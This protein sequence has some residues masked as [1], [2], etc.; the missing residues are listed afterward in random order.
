VAGPVQDLEDRIGA[1]TARRAADRRSV[2]VNNPGDGGLFNINWFEF[3]G[4]GVGTP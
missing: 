1:A 2:F 4:Q 3:V